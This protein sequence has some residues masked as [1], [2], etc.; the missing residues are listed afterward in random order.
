MGVRRCLVALLAR[1]ELPQ[2]A[3]LRASTAVCGEVLQL[4][5]VTFYGPGR[6]L[7]A[8]LA[9]CEPPQHSMLGITAVCGAVLHLCAVTSYGRGFAPSPCLIGAEIW[10]HSLLDASAFHLR[11]QHGRAALS[12][13]VA[14]AAPGLL[15]AASARDPASY[16]TCA[17]V[18]YRTLT[19]CWPCYLYFC[20]F[21]GGLPPLHDSVPP[22]S[23]VWPSSL[24]VLMWWGRDLPTLALQR[25][26]C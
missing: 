18:T 2:H 4:C 24:W 21:D 16:F 8:V 10:S 26:N 22:H 20:G 11:A 23:N 14:R 9:R 19:S 5:A 15:S 12:D 1:F 6:R 17:A 13:L 3:M 7:V 25:R